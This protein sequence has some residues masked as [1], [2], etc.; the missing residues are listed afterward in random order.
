MQ[1]CDDIFSVCLSRKWCWNICDNVGEES[2]SC[3]FTMALIL[4]MAISSCNK[5]RQW[6]QRRN[7]Q[8]GMKGIDIRK[9]F[10]VT[11]KKRKKIL[12]ALHHRALYNHGLHALHSFL[13][14]HTDCASSTSAGNQKSNVSRHQQVNSSNPHLDGAPLH[15]AQKPGEKQR[16]IA[17]SQMVNSCVQILHQ[18]VWPTMQQETDGIECLS[19]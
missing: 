11:G 13:S 10:M 2:I 19:Q 15:N 16:E 8:S 9:D 17:L 18:E 6:H 12:K 14:C 3:Y 5:E 4:V 1:R 7:I